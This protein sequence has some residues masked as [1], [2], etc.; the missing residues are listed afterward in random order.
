MC[1]L[2]ARPLRGVILLIA[3]TAC[4]TVWPKQS[5]TTASAPLDALTC[6]AGAGKQ[7]GYKLNY[8]DSTRLQLTLRKEDKAPL[9][10]EA[11]ARRDVDQIE[12]SIIGASGG[13]AA[14]GNSAAHVTI[15]A[16][17]IFQEETKRGLTDFDVAASPTVKADADTL[18]ARCAPPSSV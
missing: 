17:T 3:I 12:M 7:M 2:I 4:A 9:S 16:E 10:A 15:R 14:S 5:I 8:L 13:S 6:A 1:S 18:I 11:D